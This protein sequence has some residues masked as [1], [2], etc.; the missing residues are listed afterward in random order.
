MEGERE[1]TRERTGLVYPLHA[2]P[3]IHHPSSRRGQALCARCKIKKRTGIVNP[4]HVVSS[5]TWRE[6]PGWKRSRRGKACE[7]I[8]CTFFSH[9]ARAA[10][11]EAYAGFKLLSNRRGEA[12]Q[13]IADTREVGIGDV[14][15]TE[16]V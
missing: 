7:A 14:E 15:L 4:L 3:S 12:S 10:G 16:N 13:G 9:L 8:A 5:H 11:L 6:R 2:H 1:Q